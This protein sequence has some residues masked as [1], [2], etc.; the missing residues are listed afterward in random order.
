MTLEPEVCH[1][2]LEA[3]DRRFDGVFFV[4]ISSTQIYCRPV[5]PV[6]QTKRQHRT[7][8]PS[9]AAAEKAGYRPCLRCRPELAPG[10]AP[11]DA[12][13]RLAALAYSRIE[14][15]ALSEMRLPELAS[16]FGVTDRHLRRVI[17]LEFGVSPIELAQTQ[18]LLL[19]KRL[20]RDTSLSSIEVAV[21][22]GFQS[23]RRFHTLFKERYRMTPL[24][25]RKSR[26]TPPDWLVVDLPFRKP[27]DFDALLG[28]LQ[29]RL[30]AGV[31]AIQ[32]TT[33]CRTVSLKGQQGWIEVSPNSDSLTLRISPSL[34]K[35]FPKVVT[36]VKR[37]FD[38]YCDPAPIHS[39][40]GEIVRNPGLRVPGAFDGFEMA[41]RAILGQQITVA[42][43]ARLAGKFAAGFGKPITCPVEGLTHIFPSRGDVASAEAEEIS[44]LGMP[45]ARGR[46]IVVLA[47]AELR[48]EPYADPEPV[49]EQ[50]KAIPGIGDWTAQ[51]IAMRALGYPDAFPAGDAGLKSALSISHPKSMVAYAERWR[52]WRSYATMHLWNSLS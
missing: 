7:F 48:L 12:V 35:V 17:E 9:A 37:L 39:A 47:Q 1:A 44:A 51:Y 16:Q 28:F 18:R 40:L 2:A 14:D 23:E 15:G 49:I 4:G 30:I 8:F 25:V 6:R 33:Y 26:Q 19:A 31:E 46:T 22:S 42:G 50:L 3:K 41:V 52:P 32:D 38:L 10:R 11:M 5:C 36:R 45:R 13:G 21:A 27:Y 29:G 34:A 20:L 24:E 43:A